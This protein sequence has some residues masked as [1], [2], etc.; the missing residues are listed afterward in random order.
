MK[1]ANVYGGEMVRVPYRPF[2]VLVAKV[3][4]KVCAIE[5]ACNH[6]GASLSE[7]ARNGD[8]VVC[9]MHGYVFE[10]A[11]GKLVEPR[12]LCDDQRTFVIAV[13]DDEIV[14]WD[15]LGLDVSR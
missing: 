15:P 6:A 12:G 7:G 13:E 8:C 9:P 11:T 2:D 4:G 1:L 10:L 5:D 3:N 14:I